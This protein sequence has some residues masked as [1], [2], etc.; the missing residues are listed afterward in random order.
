ML[1]SFALWAKVKALADEKFT[2]WSIFSNID[3]LVIYSSER[4]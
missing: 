1:S 2:S 4:L 3:Q